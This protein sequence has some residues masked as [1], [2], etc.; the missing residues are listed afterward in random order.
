MRMPAPIIVADRFAALRTKL[1][2]VLGA[3]DEQDWARATVAPLWSVKDVAAHLLGGDIAILSGKRDGF[4]LKEA[5]NTADLIPLINRLN[6]EWVLAMKRVSPRLLREFLETTGPAVDDCFAALDPMAVGGPVTW[7]GPDPAPVWL[8]IARE[9]T[10]RWHHQQQIRD[11]VEHPPLY[12]PR[13]FAPVLATF[14]HAIP[15]AYREVTASPGT[16][17]RIEITGAAGGV[18]FL[19]RI[20]SRWVLCLDLPNAVEATVAIPQDV[21]WR[22]FTK[23]VDRDDARLVAFVGGNAE[24]ALP[25]FTTTAVIG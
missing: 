17:I 15:W 25:F 12:D 3:L 19:R 5:H 18:W 4:R 7:A 9:F 10:E 11:A 22:I 20:E 14:V 8:D 21:A 16:T 24:L 23:G 6:A 2:E 13:F 1:L